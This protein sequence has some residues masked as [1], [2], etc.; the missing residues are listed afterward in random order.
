MAE[1][2]TEQFAALQKRAASLRDGLV[3]AEA[4]REHIE[5]EAA[6]AEFTLIELGF[7]PDQPW[8]PQL[9][10]LQQKTEE[11]LGALEALLP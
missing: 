7:D 2:T 4:E 11:R 8:E 9:R 3:R 5:K 1:L 10:V 6:A